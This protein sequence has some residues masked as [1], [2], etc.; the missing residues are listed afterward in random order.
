MSQVRKVLGKGLVQL[1]GEQDAASV[2][3][4]SVE[5]I[6][7][8]ADQPRRGF[9]EDALAELAESVRRVGVLQP[10]VVRPIG[11]DR[12]EIIAGERRWRAAKLA[13]IERVPVVVRTSD[14]TD[15]LAL[16]LIENLQRQDLQA[17]EAA[18]AYAVLIERFGLT[19]EQVA[20]RV[21]KSRSS[22]A[23]ALRL[24]RLPQEIQQ[25]LS[26]GKITEG[27]ARALLQFETQ[28]EMLAV[29]RRILEKDLTVREVERLAQQRGAS[30]T[31]AKPRSAPTPLEQAASERL[32]VPVRI[33]R[34]K[35]GGKLEVFF[36]SDDDLDR[37]LS[38]LGVRLDD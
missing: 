21:G 22:V 35:E 36:Y 9:D 28:A 13:G 34:K 3:E 27:H 29:Y 5:C 12:Y 19:Q 33:V 17:L 25:G 6:E 16:A 38:V 23:N 2:K 31:K 4:V 20:E 1:I 11:H 8:N 7:P 37:V 26:V 32:G 15:S 18:S 30:G 10:I 14:G 24:L